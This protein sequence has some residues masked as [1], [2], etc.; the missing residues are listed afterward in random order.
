VDTFIDRYIGGFRIIEAKELARSA[1]SG[2]CLAARD[3]DLVYLC[4]GG[5]PECWP[6]PFRATGDRLRE[7]VLRADGTLAAVRA[8]DPK[9]IG[10]SRPPDAEIARAKALTDAF[11][12]CGY[13]PPGRPLVDA[14]VD[15]PARL[16]LRGRRRGPPARRPLADVDVDPHLAR[17]PPRGRRCGPAG[18]MPSTDIVS[19]LGFH[20]KWFRK[21]F[22]RD[23]DRAKIASRLLAATTTFPYGGVRALDG[24]E[25]LDNAS[26]A[27]ALPRLTAASDWTDLRARE[28]WDGLVAT[29][30]GY[31]AP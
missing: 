28:L 18:S 21:A 7:A 30:P 4:P 27:L 29:L 26:A 16:T 10:P 24:D 19:F 11:R 15:I 31:V 13:P 1:E 23:G 22:F 3:H 20:A 5:G 17:L 8:L 2:L 6:V 25:V 12:V 9:G 14:D